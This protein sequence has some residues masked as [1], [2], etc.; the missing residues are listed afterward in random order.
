MSLNSRVDELRLQDK[1][2]KQNF[3]ENTKNLFEPMTGTI[4]DVSESLMKTITENSIK[5]N[6]SI[7]DLNRKELELM[8][9]KGMIAPYL[10]SSLVNLP[11]PENKSQFKLVK[12]HK[13]SRMKNFLINTSIPVT[14]CSNMLTFGDSNISFKVDG[15]LLETKTN[16]VFIVAHSNSQDQ[17]LFFEFGKVITFNIRQKGRKSP[18]DESLIKKI[19]CY[20]GFWHFSKSFSI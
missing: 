20:H 2:G 14:L 15:D 5:N 3:L 10:A 9:D 7:S 12:V 1:L 11:K 17:K 19:V 18:W 6:Q 4:K 8:N 16:Y 13:P